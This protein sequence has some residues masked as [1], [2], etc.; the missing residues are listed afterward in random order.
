MSALL[1][2]QEDG[3]ASFHSPDALMP[4]VIFA[5]FADQTRVNFRTWDTSSASPLSPSQIMLASLARCS[6]FGKQKLDDG[7]V[8]DDQLNTDSHVTT[9]SE[10]D[11][12]F[13]SQ[14]KT[15][16]LVTFGGQPFCKEV[17]AIDQSPM[18]QLKGVQPQR[19]RLRMISSVADFTRSI[20]TMG[21]GTAPLVS[22]SASQLET[23]AAM[24]FEGYSSHFALKVD[25]YSVA[26]TDICDLLVVDQALQLAREDPDMNAEFDECARRIVQILGKCSESEL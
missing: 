1:N 19:R 16:M 7:N 26:G 4:T 20:R 14:Q 18:Q 8:Y 11:G 21:R 22:G 12:Y 9:L 3:K 2:F 15:A 10:A 23:T 5:R 6:H 25:G 13:G 24:S 17:G